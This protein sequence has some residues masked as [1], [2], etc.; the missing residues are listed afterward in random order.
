MKSSIDSCLVD[1]TWIRRVKTV[2]MSSTQV[3]RVPRSTS[4]NLNKGSLPSSWAARQVPGDATAH[5]LC[6]P[7]CSLA[8]LGEKI[9]L[10]FSTE[11]WC[12]VWC[13]ETFWQVWSC[14][15]T[16]QNITWEL[17]KQVVTRDTLVILVCKHINRTIRWF[18]WKQGLF[19]NWQAPW[20]VIICEH[21]WAR[22]YFSV[23]F[24]G[25]E[26]NFCK[27]NFKEVGAK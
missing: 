25:C 4:S 15:S 10:L 16:H 11:E 3:S 12:N 23:I 21:E 8:Q 6:W 1:N 19:G 9:L 24:E 17:L 26:A 20:H 14:T 13:V 2:L 18:T 7:G 5:H 27:V 22:K